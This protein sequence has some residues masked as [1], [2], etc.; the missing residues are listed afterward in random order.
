MIGSLVLAWSPVAAQNPPPAE[1]DAEIAREQQIVERFLTVLERNPRR[2]TALDRIYGFHVENGSLEA[3]VAMLRERT[4]KDPADGIGWMMLGLVESQR[5]RDAASVEA[6]TKAKDLRQADA[7][8]PY[9]L[10]QSLVLIGQPDQAAVAFEEAISRKPAQV[11]LLEIFQALGR[12]HQRAQRPDEALAV[13]NRL[14]KLFPGDLR[15]QEQIAVTLVE[16]GQG[17]Q[18]LPRYEALA[19]ATTDD[20]RRTVFRVEAAELKVKLNRASEGIADLEALL[21]KL[22]PE[23]WLFRE[24]RRKIEDVF[25]RTDDQD[26]LAKYYATWLEKN[27]EDVDAMARLARVLA[28]Q[29]RVPEAQVWLDKALKLAPSRRELRLA[30]IEQLVDDQRYSDALTQ[31]AALDKADP[32]NPDYLREW[33][34]LILRDTSQPK[35]VRQA[36]AERIWRRLLAARPTD[37]LVTTQ[38]ADLFRHAGFSA[39]ALELYEQAVELAPGSPQ[40]REYLGEYYHILKRTDEALATWRQIAAGKLRT[41][42]NLARLAEVLAQFGYLA[43]AQPEIAAACELAPKDFALQLK[44]ADLQ[45]RGEKYEAALVSLTKAAQL[46]QNDEEREAV[47][48]QQITAYTFQDALADLAARLDA[49]LAADGSDPQAWYLLARYREALRQWPEASRA[50]GEAL[51]LRASDIPSLAAAARITE[52][53]GDLAVSADYSRK[54]AVVDRRSKSDYLERVAQLETQL[55]RIDAAL[56]AGREL[57]SAAPGNVETYQFFADLCMRLGRPDDG[58]AALRRATR[59]N[60]NDPNIVL[61]LAAALAAQFRTDEAIELYWQAFDKG[62]SLDDRLSVVGKLTELH[63][64]INRLDQLLERLERGRREDDRRR[65]MTICLAQAYHS[66]GDYGMARQELE[67][68]LSENTRDTQL[69]LQL[70]KL[71]ESESDLTSAVKFQEQLARLAPGAETE[72]RLATLLS[73]A[74]NS[75]EAAAIIVRL[76]VKEED[77]EKL[78]RNLDSLL[79]SDQKQ[80]ALS[81]LEPKLRENATDWE[82]LYREGVALANSKPDEAARRF[83]AMLALALTDD[84]LGVAA[85]A[86]EAAQRKSGAAAASPSS[87]V[88]FSRL[89]YSYEI[90]AAV[91]L[92]S[93]RYYGGSMPRVWMPQNY[94]QARM[95]AIGWLYRFAQ[96]KGQTDEFVNVRRTGSERPEATSRELWDWAYLQAMRSETENLQETAKRLARLGEVAAAYLYL[97]QLTSRNSAAINAVSQANQPPDKTPPLAAEDL[98]LAT[99]S[100]SVVERAVAGSLAGGDY[101]IQLRQ[102]LMAE[103]RRAGRTADEQKLYQEVVTKGDNTS[104]LAQAL[105]LAARRNDLTAAKSIL[106]RFAAKDLQTADMKSMQAR[107]ARTSLGST[108]GML[109]GGKQVPPAEIVALLDRYLDYHAART[110]QQRANPLNRTSAPNIFA[111]S[112]NYSYVWVGGGRRRVGSSIPTSTTYF[113]AQSTSLLQTA[114]EQFKQKDLV[115]DLIKHLDERA[116]KAAAAEKIYAVLA[117]A[118]AQVW[119]EDLDAALKTFSAATALAPQDAELRIDVARL[120]LQFQRLDDALTMLDEVTPLDQRVLQAQET[121]ALDIAVRLGDQERARAAAQKLFGLRL[122]PETQVQ[123]AGQMRRLGMSEEADAVIARAQ[124]QAGNRL[125]ALAALMGQYQSEGRMEVAVQVAHQILRRSRTQ[126]AAMRAQGYSTADSSYRQGA[127]A[128]LSQAGKLKELIASLESQ[129]ERSPQA[130]Q[131]Y[132]T[133]SEYYQAAGE[134]QKTLDLQGKIV[135]LRPDNAELRYAYATALYSRGKYTEACD[136]YRLAIQKQPRLLENRYYE[137]QNA[138]RQAKR[139]AELIQ[140]LSELDIRRFGQPYVVINM[141]SNLIGDESQKPALMGLVKKAWEAYPSYRSQLMSSFYRADVW[142]VPEMFEFGKQSIL[143]TADAL[144]QNPWYGIGD[145]VSYSS[146]GQINTSLSYLLDAG[147]KNNRLGEIREAVAKAIAEHAAWQAGPAILAMI[148]LRLGKT[149]EPRMAL[150]TLLAPEAGDYRL[151]NARWIVGQ[152]IAARQELQPVALELL[153]LAMKDP[154]NSSSRQFQYGP[155]SSYVRLCVTAGKKDEARKV[156]AEWS[157]PNRPTEYYSSDP[158]YNLSR[159]MEDLSAIGQFAQELDFPVEGLRVYRELL[160]N[161]AYSDPQLSQWTGRNVQGYRQQA[162]RGLEA[163]ADKLADD[164]SGQVALSLLAPSGAPVDGAPA[165]D[166]ML[167]VPVSDGPLGKIDSMLA[168]LIKPQSLSKDAAAAL[169]ELLNSLAAKHSGDLSVPIMRALVELRGSGSAEG[170]SRVCEL[171]SFVN[172]HPLEEIPAGQRP[173]ARQRSEAAREIALWLVARECLPR[174][175]LRDAATQ[176]TARAIA[177]ARR[178][179][180]P[181]MV[182]AILQ[183]KGLLALEAGDRAAAERDF[184]ELIDVAVV[185]PRLPQAKSGSTQ[186][187]AAP[188]LPMPMPATPR[189]GQSGAPVRTPRAA[190]PLPATVSQFALAAALAEL[191]ADKGLH[192]VSLRAMR[193]VLSGGLPV[194]DLPKSGLSSSAPARIYRSSPSTSSRPDLDNTVASEVST[195]MAQLSAKWRQHR[196]PPSDVCALFESLVF[197]PLRPGDVLLYEQRITDN[198]TSPRS[199]GRLLVD[200]AVKAERE[201]RVREA[202]A[203]RR[204]TPGDVLAGQVLLVQLHIQLGDLAQARERLQEVAKLIETAQPSALA[205][206]AHAAGAAFAEPKLIEDAVPILTKIGA[207]EALQDSSSSSLGAEPLVRLLARHFVARRNVAGA[208]EQ[209][210]RYMTARQRHYARYGGDYGL[211]IQR[212]DLALA[213]TELGRA[214]DVKLTLAALARYADAPRYRGGDFPATIALWHLTRQLLAIAPAERYVLLRDWT[215]PADQ[216]RTLRLV[217]GFSSGQT[218]PRA[219]LPAY[220]RD[221]PQPTQHAPLSNVTLLVE[222]AK[223]AGQLDELAA[224]VQKCVDEKLPDAEGLKTLV[225]I[226]QRD[227]AG[228]RPRLDALRTA[229]QAQNK[230]E[231]EVTENARNQRPARYRPESEEDQPKGARWSDYLAAHKALTTPQIAGKGRLAMQQVVNLARRNN[232]S[233]MLVHAGYELARHQAAQAGIADLASLDRSQLRLWQANN[234]AAATDTAVPPVWVA[235]SGLV[236]HAAGSANDRLFLKMPLTGEFEFS[237]EFYSG[238]GSHGGLGYAGLMM[239]SS[240][241]GGSIAVVAGHDAVNRAIPAMR[242]EGWNRLDVRASPQRVQF[243]VNGHAV[244]EDAAPSPTSPWLCL[245]A[246]GESRL[247]IRNFQLRG[248]PQVPRDVRLVEGD[249][250]DGWVPLFADRLPLRISK[251]EARPEYLYEEPYDPYGGTRRRNLTP[252]WTAVGG[253]LAAQ[254][255]PLAARDTQSCLQYH[256]PLADGDR[257]R[258]EFYCEPGVTFVHPAL[259]GLAFMLAEDGLRLH[260]MSRGDAAA[261]PIVLDPRN[262]LDDHDARRGPDQLPLRADDWNQVELAIIGDEVSLSLNGVEVLRRAIEPG[263]HRRFGLFRFKAETTV[264]V[265]NVVLTGNWAAELTAAERADLVAPAA[266]ASAA[267]QRAR[268]AIIGEEFFTHDAYAVWQRSQLLPL[269]E[270]YKL[271][272]AWVLPSAEHPTFRLKADFTPHPAE[273]PKPDGGAASAAIAGGQI[274]SPAVEL[275]RTAREL[276]RLDELVKEVHGAAALPNVAKDERSVTALLFLIDV[277]QLDDAAAQSRLKQLVALGKDLP[278]HLPMHQRHCDLVAIRAALD[279]PAL[280][281]DALALAEQLASTPV[282]KGTLTN[283]WLPTARRLVG[284]AR[285]FGDP[286]AGDRN[287]RGVPSGLTQ[288]LAVNHATA[289]G[290]GLG[291]PYASWRFVPGQ[292][293]YLTGGGRDALVFRSPLTGDFELS[294]QVSTAEYRQVRLYYGGTTLGLSPDGSALLRSRPGEIEVNLPLADKPDNWGEWANLRLVFKDSALTLFLGD[295]QVHSERLPLHF[296]PWL[297]LRTAESHHLGSVR[298]VRILGTPTIPREVRLFAGTDLAGAVV[299]YFGESIGEDGAAWTKR[300][301]EVFGRSITNA[302][303]TFRQSLLQYHRPLAENSEVQYEFYYQP[304]KSEVHPAIDRLVFMLRPEGPRLHRLTAGAYERTGL[305]PEN[306]SPLAGSTPIPLK[307][308]D[309]NAARLTLAGS[310]IT[311]EINGQTVARRELDPGNLR[312][313]GWFH[314]SDSAEAR[315]RNIVYRGQWPTELPAVERQ[316]L[317]SQR[318]IP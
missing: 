154:T 302:P 122:T 201:D 164:S 195:R 172:S 90:Q 77:K 291:L 301:E 32:N 28:R 39:Q 128:C 270:R 37:P 240:Q 185:Q 174:P 277:T 169:N 136:Q 271:L 63:L 245:A 165:I 145:V 234:S 78:L 57:I 197:P 159:R 305:A 152:E 187:P 262:L 88:S 219:F 81:V 110:N 129:L 157:A 82:L 20:Y 183:E 15:V 44:A 292:A 282:N 158:Y 108:I 100:L 213:A 304:G 130:T 238:G 40:Y 184:G 94:G 7:L 62:G 246:P 114:F 180:D 116:A 138:F 255:D 287:G 95:A 135:D 132:E 210:D 264:R 105:G 217:A 61:S 206:A 92:N 120:L 66:A 58:I 30:F 289:E 199:V 241:W 196:F 17:A 43:E 209:I 318:P 50:I 80:T 228:V 237:C 253:E 33:G 265:R 23:S 163:I 12:V 68:L 119:S 225:Q 167:A 109:V 162:E 74:G 31:Y 232:H 252:D 149:V 51:K 91:G 260:W 244:F 10:G 294:C 295:K 224:A 314:F 83:E 104:Q 300:G 263:A 308:N 179:V 309:W 27:P 207:A 247:K 315:L 268:H 147:M 84:E 303:G 266:T 103:L 14:E 205:V 248:S 123:L 25:L 173:N 72:Y 117:L 242:H 8:A 200:W 142:D 107:S 178:Q 182:V 64:Q 127:L 99:R 288:W 235:H 286:A 56:A 79:A 71:A 21:A 86:R 42:E 227:F 35:E 96:D 49:Q 70:S 53:A 29:A 97:S 273:L 274:V 19:K 249:R 293:D 272:A 181:T 204:A 193:E 98:E 226:A 41:A 259:D 281:A 191:A 115:S 75:Q 143:P 160:T 250:F 93:E 133:L 203:A 34:K 216:R 218:I 141:I 269:D 48:A 297:T 233:D 186:Q 22:N 26:G 310:A 212:Q 194:P 236:A 126:S 11:D 16:E 146:G 279:R 278:P 150:A 198:W 192:E 156:L 290:R 161:P 171:V 87:R 4:T 2:G 316:E 131:L 267:E 112:S 137:A 89:D 261:E 251:A 176:L 67:R 60:P 221:L 317:A 46:A 134:H 118:Y 151:Q 153:Q 307:S 73:G 155:A 243:V 299:D 139:D 202:V 76:A 285:G 102:V 125:S 113:D 3:F 54:L 5:G 85:K 55:G 24:V 306:E 275:V 121:L 175:E 144:R 6:L 101:V 222:A 311:I 124:R 220:E 296:D 312:T 18:A 38:V 170:V 211:Y 177:A 257:V 36:E 45:I 254:A 280:R 284:L 190:G 239:S 1:I 298:N 276:G 258:Y 229:L 9:Y 148:D 215:L 59:V 65:E 69:L 52:Q 313:L 168:R 208:Q 106:D 214:G 47:L 166:L 189:T 230:A 140:L 283:Q 231:Q 13:W 188:T 111:A 256:R 223:Q